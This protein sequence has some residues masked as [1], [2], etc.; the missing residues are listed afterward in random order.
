[1]TFDLT[2]GGERQLFVK[3]TNQMHSLN[4][5]VHKFA[6][7]ILFFRLK[8]KLAKVPQLKVGS[9][10]VIVMFDLCGLAGLGNWCD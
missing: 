9:L 7:D 8:Q 4:E 6:F 1:M 10:V 3:P 5:H 2:G